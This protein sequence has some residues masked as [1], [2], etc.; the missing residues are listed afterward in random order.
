MIALF[1]GT[2][3]DRM[4]STAIHVSLENTFPVGSPSEFAEGGGR[5]RS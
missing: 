2:F 3:G 5:D 1:M 4:D